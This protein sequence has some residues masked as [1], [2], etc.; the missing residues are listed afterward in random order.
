[1]TLALARPELVQRL[2]LVN[3]FAYFPARLRINLAAWAARFFPDKP[4]P[5]ASRGL[6]GL[7]FFSPDISAEDRTLWWER[8]ADVSLRAYGQRLNMIVGL[9]L[10]GRLS[11]IRIPA[12]VLAAPDDRVVPS[13]AGR[14][15]ARLLP[16]AHLVKLRVGHTAMIHPRVDIARLLADPSC[17]PAGADHAEGARKS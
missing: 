10:R 12:L 6:R 4:S 3:T 8:T 11:S 5:P 16:S 14:E 15:L 7:F 1:L 17:W 2:V 13:S 9:D